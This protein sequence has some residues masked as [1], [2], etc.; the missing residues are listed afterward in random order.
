MKLMY[1]ASI[2][3]LAIVS[4]IGSAPVVAQDGGEGEIPVVSG[5]ATDEGI[6]F[7]EELTAGLVTLNF[8]NNR[9]EAIFGPV[10][11]RLNDGVTLEQVF[12][13]GDEAIFLVTLY[14]GGEVAVGESLSYTTNLPPGN[15]TLLEFEG[16]ASAQF[17]VVEGD[18]A[19]VTEPEAD[20]NV[21]LVDFAFGVPAFMPAGPQTWH[22]YNVADQW[23][24]MAIYP[25]DDGMSAAEVREAIAA[26]EEGPDSVFFWA[27][28]GAGVETWTTV[29]LEPGSY[30]MLCFL[31]DINGDF[32][33]HLDHGMLQVFTV[34]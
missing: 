34:E 20:V 14:G 15:Y 7:P 5:V 2:L 8:E 19:D 24:E 28:M 6:E 22:I 32:S 1:L 21:A 27:P 11:A 3:A 4:L 26:D 23:H 31:P 12:E 10:V 16:D 25:I 33:P 17:T 13:A 29:D 18:M 30:V 9:T